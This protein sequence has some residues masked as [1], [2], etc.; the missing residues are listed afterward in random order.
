[1]TDDKTIKK[2]EMQYIALDIETSPD[3]K[4]A[5]ML[6]DTDPGKN[7]LPEPVQEFEEYKTEQFNRD[8]Q[9][10]IDKKYVKQTTTDGHLA[11][12]ADKDYRSDW[13][14][15]KE[16]Y[17][18]KINNL[19]VQP[20]FAMVKIVKMK[21]NDELF[22]FHNPTLSYEVEKDIIEKVVDILHKNVSGSQGNVTKTR[23]LF[24]FNGKHFDVPVLIERG[25]VVGAN[26]AYSWLEL[27]LKRGDMFNHIDMIE[28]RPF[29]NTVVNKFSLNK[30]LIIRF[31]PE[32]A[33][34]EVDFDTVKFDDLDTYSTDEIIKFE[35]W[36]RQHHGLEH[37]EHFEKQM[38]M[39][40][41]TGKV[42]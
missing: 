17:D 6:D 8:K 15:M 11:K 19:A 38:K 23:T 10:I 34:I 16:N 41:Q 37:V 1:M 39:Y 24:T 22:T 3:I 25:G 21:T 5:K 14:K 35:K 2:E 9:T 30:N 13:E 31:G 32:F 33:K 27:M 36:V 26:I 7:I 40:L 12:L 28:N 4:L 20:Q 18:E 29:K 42:S